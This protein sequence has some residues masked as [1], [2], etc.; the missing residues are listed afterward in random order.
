MKP[1]MIRSERELE[2]ELSRP[3]P[4]DE[5]AMREMQGDLLILGVGG[6]MGPSLARRAVRAAAAAGIRKRIIGVARFSSAAAEKL[7][8]ESGVET[9]R[10]DLLEDQQL[11]ALPEAENVIFMAGRKF[12]STGGEGL[13][14]AVNTYLPAQIA[15]RYR[16]S[17]IVVLSSGN[18]YP[19]TPV[20]SGG[21]NENTPVGPIGEYA[22][23]VLGRERIF[24]YFSE[25][26]GTA[27][28][29]L[30][31]NYAIDLRY[32]VLLDIGSKVFYGQ[33]VDVSMG[34]VNVIW[35]GDANSVCLRSL[36]LCRTPPMVLNLTGPETLSVRE[37]AC[38]FGELLGKTPAF[39]GQEADSALLNNAGLCHSLFG[40]PAVSV[41][42]MIEWISHWIAAGG[43]MLDKPT[44]FSTRDGKF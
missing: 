42:Q 1:Q 22:Q 13:T 36:S 9:H 43:A 10:A 2:D 28:C 7:L 16:E 4:Q 31:L 34:A 41:N 35:Q 17:R 37:V 33:P 18:V 27:V 20:I 5:A 32:G 25:R 8:Q 29:L 12:G 38:R 21:A 39:E 26:H 23:S 14:W 24:E 30:R 11:A 44:H 19:L 3:S 15:R 6:K 40:Y